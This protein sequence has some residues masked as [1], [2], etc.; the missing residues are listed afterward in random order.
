MEV[1]DFEAT[2]TNLYRSAPGRPLLFSD[3]D[4]VDECDRAEMGAMLVDT[5]FVMRR[6]EHRLGMPR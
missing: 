3:L 6:M 5:G 2:A 1:P 4:H